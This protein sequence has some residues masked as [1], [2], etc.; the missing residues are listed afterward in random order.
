M[1]PK[2]ETSLERAFG[3]M[4]GQLESV[5]TSLAEVKQNLEEANEY[6]HEVRTRLENVERQHKSL[7]EVAESFGALQQSIRD[8]RM[9]VRGIVMGVGLAAGT[10]GATLPTIVQK[11]WAIFAGA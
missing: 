11:V 8:G 3:R 10:A 6:R 1:T 7:S 2:A 4:E 5:I 9:Q